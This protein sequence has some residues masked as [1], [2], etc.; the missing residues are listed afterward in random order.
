[1]SLGIQWFHH[2]VTVQENATPEWSMKVERWYQLDLPAFALT[3]TFWRHRETLKSRPETIFLAS[4]SASNLSDSQFTL[5]EP[6]SPAKFV[7]TLPNIRAA[8]VLQVMNWSG[9]VYC[10]QNDPWTVLTAL[11]EG[12]RE[13]RGSGQESWIMSVSESD[14]NITGHIFRLSPDASG[15]ELKIVENASQN[16]ANAALHDKDLFFWLSAASVRTLSAREFDL[17]RQ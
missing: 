2:T 10:L 15:C 11:A 6:P 4:P 12:L 1:M 5:S 3:E 13:V 7:H 14:G 16:M 17:S 8:S 9:Q